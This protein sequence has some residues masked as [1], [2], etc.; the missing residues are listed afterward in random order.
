MNLVQEREP[1]TPIS[2][3]GHAMGIIMEIR[4]SLPGDSP[5]RGRATSAM[6]L[7]AKLA[8]GQITL[9]EHTVMWSEFRSPRVP[10]TGS[11]GIVDESGVARTVSGTEAD[12]LLASFGITSLD[13]RARQV[14]FAALQA[15]YEEWDLIQGEV[16]PEI[17]ASRG[18]AIVQA[19]A[20][21]DYLLARPEEFPA[22][23]KQ[24]EQTQDQDDET[25]DR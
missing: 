12:Q 9:K 18:W 5:L 24:I 11:V 6:E 17:A 16:P 2:K 23:L 8:K 20:F 19:I 10:T 21:A 13:V 7:L 14:R 22:K 4:R 3:I 15:L 25:R 1:Q